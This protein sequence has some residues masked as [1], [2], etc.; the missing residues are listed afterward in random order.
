MVMCLLLSLLSLGSLEREEFPPILADF[1]TQTHSNQS[2]RGHV[3]VSVTKASQDDIVSSK[4]ASLATH[5]QHHCVGCDDDG[6]DAVGERLFSQVPK[7]AD[8]QPAQPAQPAH[9]HPHP[10][11]HVQEMSPLKFTGRDGKREAATAMSSFDHDVGERSMT[12]QLMFDTDEESQLSASDTCGEHTQGGS[13]LSETEGPEAPRRGHHL[14]KPVPQVRSMRPKTGSVD[15]HLL[16]KKSRRSSHG[17][18]MSDISSDFLLSPETTDAD[19]ESGVESGIE[20]TSSSPSP[21]DVRSDDDQKKEKYSA[22][23]THYLDS[24][25]RRK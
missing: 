11:G 7:D 8:A 4:D 22:M 21:S 15:E 16:G 9:L 3:S 19:V 25:S 20:S 6:D 5:H 10:H 23:L 24:L 13:A 2:G 17:L 12:G 14:P 1:G 18:D